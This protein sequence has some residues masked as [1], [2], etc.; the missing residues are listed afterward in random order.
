MRTRL[1]VVDDRAE[2]RDFLRTL[3]TFRGWEVL[4][5]ADGEHALKIASERKPHLIVA[6]VV[7]PRM[8]G[9]DLVRRLRQNPELAATKVIFY[10]ATYLEE[11]ARALARDCGVTHVIAKPAEPE[12]ILRIV[13]EVLQIEQQAVPMLGQTF[14][15]EHLRLITD[16]LSEKVDE[17]ETLNAELE[18]RVMAR[19]AELA[20]ANARLRELDAVKNEFLA[21][22]SHDLRSPLT[23]IL[24]G[25]QMMA[26]KGDSMEP[27]LRKKILA[28]TIEATEQQ[29]KLANDL[30]TVARSESGDLKLKLFEFPLSDAVWESRRTVSLSAEAKGIA[31]E[32]EIAPDEP[33]PLGDRTRLVEMFNNLLTN[34][35][36]FTP[37]GGCVMVKVW[38]EADSIAASVSDTGIGI[39]AEVLPHLFEK[40]KGHRPGTSGE[41]GTG[42][43][44]AIVQQ[45]VELHGGTIAVQSEPGAG[46]TFTVRLP[47]H[48]SADWKS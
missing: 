36:K 14:T 38:P 21:V 33:L 28:Q 16:K 24:L 17:L 32:V 18:A 22:V 12:E 15:R 11:E 30:L 35:L 47:L 46:A 7:M 2:N 3:F 20:Q 48:R 1:L 41:T 5:A 39:P 29:V 44:L 43:G 34:A 9:Y 26:Q 42:L 23:G 37:A 31:I 4:E 10:T 40:F 6:D 8:D 13:D 45:I 19:T 27:A 25:A